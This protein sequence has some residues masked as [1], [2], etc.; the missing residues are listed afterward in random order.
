MIATIEIAWPNGTKKRIEIEDPVEVTVGRDPGCTICLDKDA[1]TVSAHHLRIRFDGSRY[2][3]EDT[4]SANGVFLGERKVQSAEGS[5]GQKIGLGTKGPKLR[6]F[7]VAPTVLEMVSDAG[8]SAQGGRP[9]QE[10]TIPRKFVPTGKTVEPPPPPGLPGQALTRV[11]SKTVLAMIEQAIAAAREDRGLLAGGTVFL[12]EIVRQTVEESSRPLKAAVA[13]VC[14]LVLGLAG[15]VAYT[16]IR[17]QRLARATSELVAARFGQVST[18]I[19]DSAR[20]QAASLMMLKRSYE[21]SEKALQNQLNAAQNGHDRDERK[22]SALRAELLASRSRAAQI[23]AHLA[24][25]NKTVASIRDEASQKM[26][27]MRAES[28]KDLSKALADGLKYIEEK[29]KSY[30]GPPPEAPIE[31]AGSAG[32]PPEAAPAGSIFVAAASGN[33][34][35]KKRIAIDPVKIDSDTQAY[36]ASPEMVAATTS[37]ILAQALSSTGG[38]EIINPAGGEANRDAPGG[39]PGSQ[40]AMTVEMTRCDVEQHERSHPGWGAI[41]SGVSAAFGAMAGSPGLGRDGQVIAESVRQANINVN[42]VVTDSALTATVGLAATLRDVLTGESK[43]ISSEATSSKTAHSYQAVISSAYTP[44]MTSGKVVNA[45]SPLTSAIAASAIKL[46]AE[47]NDTLRRTAWKGRIADTVDAQTVVI[48]AGSQSGLREGD[49]FHVAHREAPITDPGSGAVLGY[50][51]QPAGTIYAVKV[52]PA[53]STCVVSGELHSPLQRGDDIEFVGL[54]LPSAR[55]ETKEATLQRVA[56]ESSE[57]T[58]IQVTKNTKF[59]L[60]PAT[61]TPAKVKLSSGELLLVRASFGDWIEVR[62]L[63]GNDL[64]VPVGATPEIHGS[65]VDGERLQ[66]TSDNVAV[67]LGPS[68]NAK[69]ASKVRAGTLIDPEF[70]LPGWYEIALPEGHFGWI[71]EGQLQPAAAGGAAS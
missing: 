17:A 34:R 8:A 41:L 60:T 63:E 53:K 64:W 4:N 54:T 38:F 65:A 13:V 52:A 16:Q 15:F 67:R 3:V 51:S 19:Q 66:V 31:E 12:R 11:G 27:E 47:V 28:R 43:T 20:K 58:F 56:R 18:R 37:A 50:N 2:F 6:I 32:Q 25:T 29:E 36:G 22:I 45:E 35:L 21:D 14:G 68:D 7:F 69:A 61:D 46:S 70:Y 48:N 57:V 9:S 24:Q 49:T 44:D 71:P 26:G 33:L 59:Y 1:D 55:G 23:A 10:T 30:L 62:G 5:A 40:Y 42:D 39:S